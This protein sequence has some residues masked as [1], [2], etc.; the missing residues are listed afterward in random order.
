[1]YNRAI[2]TFLRTESMVSTKTGHGATLFT[3]YSPEF[4]EPILKSDSVEVSDF[5]SSDFIK[6]DADGS[7]IS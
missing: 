3:I 4:E 6:C 2:N 7:Y 1:M 5:S